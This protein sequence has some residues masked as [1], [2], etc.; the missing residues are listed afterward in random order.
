MLITLFSAIAA[1]VLSLAAHDALAQTHRV[2]ELIETQYIHGF[3]DDSAKVLS[4][5]DIPY[6]TNVL[7][8]TS[9]STF[10]SNAIAALSKIDDERVVPIITTFFAGLKGPLNPDAFSAAI[11]VPSALSVR[12]KDRPELVEAL[13]NLAEG[14]PSTLLPIHF[15]EITKSV[16]NTQRTFQKIAV[17]SLGYSPSPHALNYLESHKNTADPSLLGTYESAIKRA[18]KANVDYPVLRRF[19]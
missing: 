6:L 18:K 5:S 14:K 16:E 4:S 1:L 17:F 12:S 13:T 9:K 2:Q 3:P 15:Y 10:W 7:N 19:F 8:D 11:V